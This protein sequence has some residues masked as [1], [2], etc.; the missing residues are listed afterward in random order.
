[1]FHIYSGDANQDIQNALKDLADGKVDLLGPL[2]KAEGI[3]ENII[4]PTQSYGTVYTHPL[5]CTGRK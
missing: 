3:N 5:Y 2:L 4:F 1:M